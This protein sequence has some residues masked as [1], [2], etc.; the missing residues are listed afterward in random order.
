M[1][2]Y[3]ASIWEHGVYEHSFVTLTVDR[4]EWRF[5]RAPTQNNLA[6][7]SSYKSPSV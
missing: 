7:L 4:V 2:S 6:V 5:V 1:R 3:H